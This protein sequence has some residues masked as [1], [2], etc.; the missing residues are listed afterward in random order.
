MEPLIV[1]RIGLTHRRFVMSRVRRPRPTR[2]E[3][4]RLTAATVRGVVSGIVSAI[5]NRLIEH[6]IG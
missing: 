4:R 2:T 1:N 5:V 3:R 6:I